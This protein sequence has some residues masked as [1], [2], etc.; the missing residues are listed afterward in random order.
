MNDASNIQVSSVTRTPVSIRWR[1]LIFIA[2]YMG[3]I[4]IL[5][6]IFAS[7]SGDRSSILPTLGEVGVIFLFGIIW[8]PWGF[9]S[10]LQL[11]IHNILGSSFLLLILVGEGV[12]KPANGLISF[13][14]FLSY[15]L[16]M[17][18][19][20]LGSLTKYQ[21]SFRL[22]YLAFVFLLILVVVLLAHPS[23]LLIWLVIT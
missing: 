6:L 17:I 23:S 5:S 18:I 7:H 12:P 4:A 2:T 3:G 19:P 15:C 13:S 20:I 10:W 16:F 1:P 9:L 21:K 22:L 8:V 11:L 14:I